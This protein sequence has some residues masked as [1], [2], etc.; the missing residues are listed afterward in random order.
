MRGGRLVGY[1]IK[2][3]A[4]AIDRRPAMIYNY[5]NESDESKAFYYTHREARKKGGFLYDDEV[6]ERLKKRVGVEDAVGVG[7]K[8]TEGKEVPII[9]APTIDNDIQEKNEKIAE[10]EKVNGELRGEISRLMDENKELMRQNS[11]ILY[12][13]SQEKSEKQ[14]L[15]PPPR[16]SI[17]KRI[18]SIFKK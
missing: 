7:I 16:E 18:K 12:L 11:T 4:A 6:L 13:L 15:L 10:L 1:T 8:E 9:T 5:F 2:E 17:G 3:L 14:A